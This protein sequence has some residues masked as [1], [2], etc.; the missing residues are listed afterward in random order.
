[1]NTFLDRFQ[2]NIR[3]T[4]LLFDLITPIILYFLLTSGRELLSAVVFIVVILI[5]VM[6]VVLS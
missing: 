1:M 6:Y 2:K 3:T 5:R 4:A